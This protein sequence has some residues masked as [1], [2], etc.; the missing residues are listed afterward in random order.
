[1]NSAKGEILGRI[2]H[3]LK[4][5][6]SARENDYAGIERRYRQAGS[7]DQQSRLNLFEER[8]RDY[9]AEV[10]RCPDI[11]IAETIAQALTSRSMRRLLI[12]KDLPQEWLPPHP[13]EFVRHESLIYEEMDQSEG[14]LTGCAVAVALTG[15]IVS[16]HSSG[17]GRRALTLIPDYHLCVVHAAKVVETVSEG[18]RRI[19]EFSTVPITTISDPSAT[20]DIELTRIKG[21][22]GPRTLDLIL[23]MS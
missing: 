14:V 4:E 20:S 10:Y 16:R 2:R 5:I 7:L 21:V 19:K 18:I 9:R 3:Y 12:P 17:D 6:P 15:T 23:V 1:M 13:F 22:H 11:R 8:L